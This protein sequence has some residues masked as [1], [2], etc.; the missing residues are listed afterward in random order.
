MQAAINY[1][2]R[3]GLKLKIIHSIGVYHRK[4]Y[5]TGRPF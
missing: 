3:K 5:N 4:K 2:K 1:A